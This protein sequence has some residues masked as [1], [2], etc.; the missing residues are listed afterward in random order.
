MTDQEAFREV[1]RRIA[2]GLKEGAL[3]LNLGFFQLAKMP[4]SLGQLKQ[5]E[6]LYIWG[7]RL[8]AL[9]E[10]LKQLPMLQYLNLSENRLPT[11][12]ESLGQSGLLQ[13]LDVSENQLTALPQGLGVVLKHIKEFVVFSHH[14]SV[15]TNLS[16]ELRD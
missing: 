2:L 7:N 14:Y 16:R 9:P 3:E 10:E 15:G 11:L 6:Q 5:L 12:P 4:E 8:T 1:E 13:Y